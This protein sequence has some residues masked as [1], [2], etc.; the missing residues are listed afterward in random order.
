[1][2]M[3]NSFKRFVVATLMFA[4]A[5]LLIPAVPARAAKLSK[6]IS[7]EWMQ[8]ARPLKVN[9]KN[10]ITMWTDYRGSGDFYNDPYN[11][12]SSRV[13]EY[14]FSID[15]P[16]S[17]KMTYKIGFG[18]FEEGDPEY[19]DGSWDMDTKNYKVGLYDSNG[20]LL[21]QERYWDGDMIS[22]ATLTFRRPEIVS[23]R[24]YLRV[25]AEDESYITDP[26]QYIDIDL[27]PRIPTAE[28]INEIKKTGN[29]S[30]QI[31]WSKTTAANGYKIYRAE[32]KNGKYVEIKTVTGG[33]VRCTLTGVKKNK[34]YYYKVKAYR[35]I[36]GKR[37]YS[38]TASIKAF[39]LK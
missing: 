11:L 14:I 10:R 1:M 33:K 21:W 38:D 8:N 15:V 36:N 17:V 3:K 35:L 12:G 18:F 25:V 27:T 20:K 30:V 34:T 28:K 26:A 4:F 24:C 22:F 13:R 29:N 5:F 37:Y 19:E 6:T 31:R 16:R 23:S 7:K 2:R 32:S 39:T 9:A